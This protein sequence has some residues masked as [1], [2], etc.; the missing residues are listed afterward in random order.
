MDS[1]IQPE[2]AVSSKELLAEPVDISSIRAF[3][4]VC[5]KAIVEGS[6]IGLFAGS[7]EALAM[8]WSRLMPHVP[9]D[10]NVHQEVVLISAKEAIFR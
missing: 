2:P 5:T 3:K 6:E 1:Q 4:G 7:V 9:F 10:A 8:A